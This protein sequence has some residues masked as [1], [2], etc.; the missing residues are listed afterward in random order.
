LNEWHAK[1][2]IMPLRLFASRGRVGAYAAR[3]LYLGGMMG[4]W[5]FTTQ[6]LQGVLGY[7]PLTAGLAFLPTTIPN[8]ASAIA[9][10][11]L[12]RLLGNGPLLA[13]GIASAV[14]GMLWLAQVTGVSSY[15]VGVALPMILIGVG[16]GGVL[17]PLTI[18]GVSG[19]APEDA[20]AASGLVNATHQLGGS[21]GLA[22]LVVVFASADGGAAASHDILA[23]QI[24]TA[25]GAGAIMLA[26]AL[27]LVLALIV[28]HVKAA[29]PRLRTPSLSPSDNR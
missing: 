25:F 28:P 26:L 19:V 3:G 18:A 14:I 16:Q 23:H 29:D 2:P 11:K 8:F 7:T 13:V 15:L 27:A 10:P 22:I 24:A 20:G 6:F 1:Q 21:L 4:F 5:F 17:G 12:T 9:V